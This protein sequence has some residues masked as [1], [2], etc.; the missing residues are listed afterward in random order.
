MSWQ[1]N[2]DASAF[3]VLLSEDEELGFRRAS[4]R[5]VDVLSL[6]PVSGLQ[7]YLR[8]YSTLIDIQE[9]EYISPYGKKVAPLRN[10]RIAQMISRRSLLDDGTITFYKIKNT[11]SK[12]GAIPVLCWLLTIFS[13]IIFA[14]LIV[15]SFLNDSVS[16]IGTLT[17]SALPYGPYFSVHLMLFHL[18]QPK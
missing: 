3:L 9:R 13:W 4:K 2:F 15:V 17:S 12:A 10:I 16:W 7:A 11:S 8:D 14:A 6:A 18:L 1:W 5:L